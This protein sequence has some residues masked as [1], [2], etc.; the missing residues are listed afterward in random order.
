MSAEQQPIVW[1][2]I[3]CTYALYMSTIHLY[4]YVYT[5]VCICMYVYVCVCIYICIY[6]Y[7]YIRDKQRQEE[8][9]MIHVIYQNLVIHLIHLG[10]SK[11]NYHLR[12]ASIVPMD[13][14]E[15]PIIGVNS[16]GFT[17]SRAS[18]TGI[19]SWQI[20]AEWGEFTTKTRGFVRGRMGTE[21]EILRYTTTLLH[22]QLLEVAMHYLCDEKAQ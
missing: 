8:M 16:R 20:G 11:H 22:P 14:A 15:V 3:A 19:P 18:C 9:D 12:M 2:T 10:Q 17:K 4:T 21:W 5:H 1:W 13:A 7:T 6:I